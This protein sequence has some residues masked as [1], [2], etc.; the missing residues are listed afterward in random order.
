MSNLFALSLLA[1]SMVA[2]AHA[3]VV[4][5]EVTYKD[6][7]TLLKGFIAYDDAVKGKR[8]GVIVVPEWWGITKHVKDYARELA[9]KGY[10]ALAVDMYGNG[11]T[12]DEPKLAGE[13]SG[14]VYKAPAVMKSRFDAGRSFLASQ[15][16]VDASFHGS[17][18]TQAPAKPGDV[19]AKVL[20]LN[21]AADP[22]VKPE[23]V[24]AFKKE[25]DAAKVDYKFID[26]PG[27][28]HA[29]TNPEATE[30]GKK[31]NLPLAYDEKADKSSKVEM[32]KFF[33]DLFAKR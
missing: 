33:A 12:A 13:L 8:P 19:K 31:F 22:F 14:A 17:L 11:K 32:T 7:D 15:A 30:K 4:L 10:T 28:V 23:A 6:G 16:T 29:F 27:A 2:P 3:S 5:K 25:F 1:F 9:A 18:G 26:Y 24:A 20:V 21:G